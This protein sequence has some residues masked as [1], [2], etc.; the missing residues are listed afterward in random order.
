METI[1]TKSLKKLFKTEMYKRFNN[2]RKIKAADNNSVGILPV[3]GMGATTGAGSDCYPHTIIEV[4]AD[5]SYLIIQ[6]D[7]YTKDAAFDYYANQKYLYGFN[8]NG[9]TRKYTLRKNGRYI[10]DGCSISAYWQTC[11]L[12]Y[13][14]YYQDPHF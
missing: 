12:G 10:A 6:A 4:A 3:V 5:F 2:E 1:A 8:P 9:A 7:I 14:R 11:Y 13:R